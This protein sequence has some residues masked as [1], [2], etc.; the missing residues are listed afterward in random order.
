MRHIIITKKL[1]VYCL[2]IAL[3]FPLLVIFV[4]SPAIDNVLITETKGEAIRLAKYIHHIFNLQNT[5]LRKELFTEE[6]LREINILKDQFNLYNVLFFSEDGEIIFSTDPLAT[7]S[8][9]PMDLFKDYVSKGNNFYVYTQ[10]GSYSHEGVLV[11][12]DVVE[13]YLPIFQ[14]NNLIGGIEIYYDITEAKEDFKSLKTLFS[15][16]FFVIGF[17]LL[18]L[19]AVVFSSEERSK[20]RSETAE[21]ELTKEQLKAEAVFSAMGDNVIV[22]DR[23]YKIIYQNKVNKN[24]FGERAGELCH[25]VY[26]GLDNICEGCPVELTYID[27]EGH[28]LEKK[29][30]TKDGLIYIELV[31]S[32]IYNEEGEIIAGVKVV[33]DITER[34]N[35]ERQLLQAQKMEAVGQLAGGVAHDFNNIMTAIM[36]YGELLEMEIEE[37]S[38]TQSKVNAILSSAQKA[39][40]LTRGLLTFSRKQIID[41]KVVMLNEIVRELG[42]LLEHLIS[43]DIK[44]R[45]VLTEDDLP[46]L[47]DPG[48]IEQAIMNLTTNARDAM[49]SG[50]VLTVSTDAV[51][52]DDEYIKAH[53][54]GETGRYAL[55]SIE[56]S[57]EGM[58]EETKGKIFEPFFTTKGLG[59]G[60]GLGLAM[61]YGIIKQ[62]GG[63]INVYS[64]PGKGTIFRIYIPLTTEAARDKM[65]KPEAFDRL[66]RGTETILLA[67]DDGE[68]R[69]L[70]K[71]VLEDHGY[72][73]HRCG[74]RE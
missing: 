8:K 59:R 63:Y 32:P 2:L 53:G 12:A 13:T 61:V 70:I 15:V 58:D 37:D 30:Q 22:Q 67:E 51:E 66:A 55:L 9:I 26:E 42:T 36:G 74:R 45:T 29:V 14:A 23:D 40:T 48:Q 4:V 1:L 27:G 54:Y 64:E 28:R 20:E 18:L 39:A 3:I 57:G 47:V 73:C 31:S 41:P 46:I 19:I 68:V 49:P 17:F 71:I 24:V 5:E 11:N 16:L 33:R 35:L 52:F 10:K 6:F 38:P 65:P 60:T 56:D 50:G 62:N 21:K 69:K 43:E 34:R 44:L 25:K 7:E 72:N